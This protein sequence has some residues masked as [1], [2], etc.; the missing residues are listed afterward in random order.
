[1]FALLAVF[2][3]ILAIYGSVL[4]YKRRLVV[5]ESR[6]DLNLT[7]LSLISM[8]PSGIAFATESY[9]LGWSLL[10]LSAVLIAIS[11]RRAFRVNRTVWHGVL[12]VFAKYALLG[13]V[14]L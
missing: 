9:R 7:C 11:V 1:M 5:Y 3:P 6:A 13:L 8:V 12:S 2:V 14:A 10:V 4:G